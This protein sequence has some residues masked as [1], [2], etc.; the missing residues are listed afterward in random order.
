MFIVLYVKYTISITMKNNIKFISNYTEKI[1]R[2][3]NSHNIIC[4]SIF[5][6]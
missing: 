5:N 1:E 2:H 6:I 4:L 3:I